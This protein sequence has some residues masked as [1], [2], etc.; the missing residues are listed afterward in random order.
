VSWAVGGGAHWLV[1]MTPEENRLSGPVVCVEIC[2]RDTS[3]LGMARST[4]SSRLSRRPLRRRCWRPGPGRDTGRGLLCEPRTA[5]GIGGGS[6]CRAPRRAPGAIATPT[7]TALR[8]H[9]ATPHLRLRRRRLGRRCSCMRMGQTLSV[10]NRISTERSLPV[11]QERGRRKSLSRG[12]LCLPSPSA[13]RLAHIRE[14]PSLCRA[15]PSSG[16]PLE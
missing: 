3:R 15:G 9:R 10:L 13:R 5:G 8:R 16:C 11:P 1:G 12:L 6:S 14:G 2:A 7:A 4:P